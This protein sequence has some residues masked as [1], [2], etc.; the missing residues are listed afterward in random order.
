MIQKYYQPSLIWA[1][2]K[3][4]FDRFN[5]SGDPYLRPELYIYHKSKPGAWF[6]HGPKLYWKDDLGDS[7]FTN[8]SQDELWYSRDLL[9][10]FVAFKIARDPR[11]TKILGKTFEEFLDRVE[12]T[13]FG[14]I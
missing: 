10:E 5:E 11:E 2:F 3:N 8:C 1:K 7:S 9:G 6:M 4:W 12:N 14:N 13:N